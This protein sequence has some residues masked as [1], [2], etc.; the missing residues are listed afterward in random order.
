MAPSLKVLEQESL[1]AIERAQD[2]D[3]LEAVGR[4]VLGRRSPLTT[5]LRALKDHPDP[6]AQG[7]R[8]NQIKKTLTAAL[9]AREAALQQSPEETLPPCD[10]TLP[11]EDDPVFR[12]R[13]HP[14]SQVTAELV[15]IF[16]ALGFGVEEGP[17]IE[18]EYHNFTALNI[19]PD[20]PARQMHDT[21]YVQG[22]QLLRTHTSP[23]QIRV[24][25]SQ[26]PPFRFIAPG[27]TY[28][29]DADQTHTPM[30][31]QLEGLVVEDGIHL[32]HLRWTLEACLRAFFEVE[33]VM[34]RFRPSFFP[35]TEPSLEVDVRYAPETGRVGAGESWLEVLGCG[36]VHP[37]VLEG[38]GL[39]RRHFQGFAFGMGIDR[40]A[41]LKY[42]ME[43]L[44]AFFTATD[45]WLHHYGVSP[46]H[47]PT[48]SGGLSP[49]GG[50]SL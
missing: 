28:R 50:M 40:L 25:E 36:M 45:S 13:I 41:M 3:S 46:L 31:H 17:E 48:L 37:R 7:A 11:V 35:F 20:H 47:V 1:Q 8:L 12:G 18:D 29:R 5:L 26:V 21:F 16:T 22:S 44:R 10:V 43:D 49:H 19:P 24:M 30:F 33:A 34:L 14:I 23:V 32:G 4:D 38:C 42:G 6:R 27:R 2:L 39:D 9:K 15:E